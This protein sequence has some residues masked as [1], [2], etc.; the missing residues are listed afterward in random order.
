MAQFTKGRFHARLYAFCWTILETRQPNFNADIVKKQSPVLTMIQATN[1][2]TE[3]EKQIISQLSDLLKSKPDINDEQDSILGALEGK[4]VVYQKIDPYLLLEDKDLTAL[5]NNGDTGNSGTSSMLKSCLIP[6]AIFILVTI[7]FRIHNSDYFRERRAYRAVTKA[8]FQ[9]EKDD[10]I[11]A[12][13]EDFPDGKHAEDVYYRSVKLHPDDDFYI[14]RYMK[15]FY[16]SEHYDEVKTIYDEC[17]FHYIERRGYRMKDVMAYLNNIP[18]GAYTNEVNRMCDSIWDAEINKYRA[19]PKAKKAAKATRYLDAMLDYMKK[20]RVNVLVITTESTYKLKDYTEYSQ[21]V[22][23]IM[24]MNDRYELLPVQGNVISLKDNF[25]RGNQSALNQILSQGLQASFDSIFTCGF[26]QVVDDSRNYKTS[27]PRA[28]FSYEIESQEDE[29]WGTAYPQLW[30]YYENKIPKKYLVG[31]SISCRVHFTIPNSDIT[32][33]LSGKG[34]PE[35][36]INGIRDITDGYRQMTI[37]SFARFSNDL[38][39]KFG[40]KEVY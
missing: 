3:I 12:Y 1:Y 24:E 31:I 25:S 22:R 6:L 35:K 19:Q 13:I 37:M 8:L 11:R 16:Q 15:K 29:I 4:Q 2:A 30:V 10:A 32:Y 38:Y 17:L 5:T 36:D 39:A 7:G 9:Y 14:T 33:E 20:L 28:V 18:D 34:V 26:I 21:A 23:D 27:Y 40:L